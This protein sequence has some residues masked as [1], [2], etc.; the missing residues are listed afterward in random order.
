MRECEEDFFTK[1]PARIP[2]EIKR[3]LFHWRESFGS[4]GPG[5]PYSEFGRI[6]LS[7]QCD[8]SESRTDKDVETTY[9]IW[10][11]FSAKGF[12]FLTDGLGDT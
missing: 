6:R 2:L 9:E 12:I 5:Y 8:Y 7:A 4:L 10:N 1:R 11:G 3:V